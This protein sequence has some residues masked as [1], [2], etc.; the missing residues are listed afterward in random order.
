MNEKMESMEINV[1][2]PSPFAK[3]D[4]VL[5]LG[6]NAVDCYVSDTG[7]RLISMRAT[8]KAIAGRDG[9]GVAEYIGVNALKPY[10][11]ADLVAAELIELSIPG[12]PVKAKCLESSRFLEICRAYVNA[13]SAN[14]LSTDRQK[15]IAIKCSILLSACAN[16]G[17]DALIDEATGY[18]YERREDEM[19]LRLRLYIAEELR[20]WEK[21]FPDEL[22]EEFGRL[23]N[24]STPLKGRPKW[25]GKLV[26]ELIYDTLDPVV[27]KWIRENPPPKGVH[28]HRNLTDN[29]GAKQLV[30]RCWEII[31]MSK[32]CN[33]ISELRDKVNYH[34][35]G[36]N[37]QMQLPV[38]LY[39]I[40]HKSNFNKNLKKALNHQED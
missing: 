12:N 29:Y 39:E 6:D 14:A 32:G 35:K 24:W 21:T 2:P 17:L 18:Q 19:Q 38:E 25:W 23:T 26:I 27:A 40:D 13:L 16:V 3:Y 22:W 37:I 10:I 11:D 30:S 34:Y 28:W 20:A 8:M 31:G 15:E 4:G 1:M 9:G 36:G 7:K 5:K 33:S